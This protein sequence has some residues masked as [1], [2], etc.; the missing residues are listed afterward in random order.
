MNV[1]LKVK[2]LLSALC[3][4]ISNSNWIG[5]HCSASFDNSTVGEHSL[6]LLHSPSTS[7]HAWRN[8]WTEASVPAQ[9]SFVNF[10]SATIWTWSTLVDAIIVLDP[11]HVHVAEVLAASSMKSWSDSKEFDFTVTVRV[12]LIVASSD[13]AGNTWDCLEFFWTVDT[14]WELEHSKDIIWHGDVLWTVRRTISS[15]ELGV[16]FSSWHWS[17][18]CVCVVHL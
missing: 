8:K 4:L 11:F 6:W 15:F 10:Q 2:E 1:K 16:G 17:H 12:G 18:L 5:F 9:N 7:A 14:H 3:L 13:V